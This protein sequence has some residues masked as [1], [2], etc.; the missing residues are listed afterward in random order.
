M[1]QSSI[2]LFRLKCDSSPRFSIPMSTSR[3]VLSLT[4]LC[5]EFC[6]VLCYAMA[7]SHELDWPY[8]YISTVHLGKVFLYTA[9]WKLPL[10]VFRILIV[11]MNEC[12]HLCIVILQTGEICLDILKTAWSPA[13]TLQSVCRAVI[14]LL[15]HPEADSPLNCDAGMCRHDTFFRCDPVLLYTI[16]QWWVRL[17]ILRTEAGFCGWTCFSHVPDLRLSCGACRELT[18]IRWQPW[19]P[20]Y[21]ADVYALMCS[22]SKCRTTK[23]FVVFKLLVIEAF[24][25]QKAME[26]GLYN[27]KKIISNCASMYFW[28]IVSLKT[29]SQWLRHDQRY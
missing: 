16:S 5:S 7:S 1:Y 4:S 20:I 24:R 15:A 18:E 22:S 21:V 26:N 11:T 12:A 10:I 19:L 23:F 27:G 29:L 6:E 8:N 25:L 13:W 3:L 2:L 9:P 14:A 17:C 28:M